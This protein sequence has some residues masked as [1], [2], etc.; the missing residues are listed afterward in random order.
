MF[1]GA[2]PQSTY[3]GTSTYRIWAIGSHRILGVY[4]DHG[5][6]PPELPA[7]VSDAIHGD[8]FGKAFYGDYEV[9]PTTKR[10]AGRM[11]MV[12]VKSVVHLMVQ[13]TPQ[14]R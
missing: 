2:W 8:A 6:A 4:D 5:N 11:Q 12:C 14:L 1:F 3:N 7:P 13:Q 9:C 10:V